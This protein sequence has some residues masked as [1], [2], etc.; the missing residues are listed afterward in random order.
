MNAAEVAKPT[1]DLTPSN[2]DRTIDKP[3]V[4]LPIK[5]DA[6]EARLIVKIDG[7]QPYQPITVRIARD[8]PDW[9]GMIS[10]QNWMGK[11]LTIVPKTPLPESGWIRN[12][13]LSDQPPTRKASIKK[14]IAHNSTSLRA[15]AG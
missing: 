7:E 3:Y 14:N 8:K 4:H 10:V 6:P 9:Y 11:K 15:A 1:N 2:F 13:K 12:M 5:D